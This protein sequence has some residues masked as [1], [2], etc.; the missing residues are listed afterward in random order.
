MSAQL[1]TGATKREVQG[2]F[3]HL[4]SLTGAS[5]MCADG[6]DEKQSKLLGLGRKAASALWNRKEGKQVVWVLAGSCTS[7]GLRTRPGWQA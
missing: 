4:V 3:R 5:G 7:C 6:D 1:L 2:I